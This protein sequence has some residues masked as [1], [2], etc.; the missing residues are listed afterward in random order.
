MALERLL[1]HRRVLAIGLWAATAVVALL[2]IPLTVRQVATWRDDESLWSREI[3]VH[4]AFEIG[5]YSR[6]V[7]RLVAGKAADALVDL[8]EAR[9]LGLVSAELSERMA[10]AFA[11]TGAIDSALA[12]YDAALALEPARTS[13]QRARA[14]TLL[15]VGQPDAAL[16]DL[17][18]ALAHASPDSAA[19]L[20]PRGLAL[21]RLGRCP[22]AIAAL[23]RALAADPGDVIA[24]YHRALC[25]LQLGD[26][27][28]A[29]LDLRLALRVDPSFQPARERLT[30]L[31]HVRGGRP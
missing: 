24:L 22:E 17:D 7:S 23:D 21:E 9:R 25:R 10:D 26:A 15:R 31:E 19:L 11:E 8:R 3:R 16:R 13:V 5:W 1:A 4:P 30:Q 27:A 2:W 18:A 29:A 28:G 14:I 20:G 6:G 12:G